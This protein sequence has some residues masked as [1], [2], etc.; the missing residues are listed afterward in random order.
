M[1]ARNIVTSR[2]VFL[3]GMGGLTL[4]PFSQA[5]TAATGLANILARASDSALDKLAQ[6]DAFYNDEAIRISFPIVGDLGDKLGNL[7]DLTSGLL[8]GSKKSDLLGGITRKLNDVAVVAAGEAK[9]IFRDSINGLSLSDAPDIISEKDGA[10]QYLRSSSS[11][12]LQNKLRPLVDN[13]MNDIGVYE[14]LDQ[15]S[16]K[17]NIIERAGITNDSLGESVT[18]QALNGIFT[19]IG[20]EEANFRANPLENANKLLDGF[21]K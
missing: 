20:N 16:Q 19:Y 3:L 8:G 10:T 4:M 7:S 13:S 18:E 21:F 1:A 6:P 14:E 5:A 9:P 2:R 17:N 15:L 11:E 12:T